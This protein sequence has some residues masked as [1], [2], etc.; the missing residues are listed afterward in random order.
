MRLRTDRLHV[1]VETHLRVVQA[2]R[3]GVDPL[4][5]QHGPTGHDE[6][7]ARIDLALCTIDDESRRRLVRSLGQIVSVRRMP[8]TD[9]DELSARLM[10]HMGLEPITVAWL[11]A[12]CDGIHVLSDDHQG[13]VVIIDHHNHPTDWDCETALLI[14]LKSWWQ[15]RGMISVPAIPDTLAHQITG[16]PLRGI[17]SHPLLDDLTLHVRHADQDD[18]RLEILST[19]LAQSASPEEIASIRP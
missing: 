8:E 11:S 3:H 10:A 14:G 15:A 19:H 7:A 16:R 5:L 6:V 18:G 17:V 9:V 13:P 2:I 4:G 12:L 1:S